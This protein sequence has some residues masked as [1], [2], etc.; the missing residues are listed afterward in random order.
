MSQNLPKRSLRNFLFYFILTISYL[1]ARTI[2]T[3]FYPTIPCGPC[4]SKSRFFL[5][6]CLYISTVSTFLIYARAAT[7]P[8][9]DFAFWARSL[10]GNY[11]NVWTINQSKS[12]P[13][14]WVVTSLDSINGR[15]IQKLRLSFVMLLIHGKGV[16][17]ERNTTTRTH[18]FP[19]LEHTKMLQKTLSSLYFHEMSPWSNVKPYWSFIHENK[20]K[21]LKLFI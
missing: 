8:P 20:K 2:E 6:H 1:T 5:T 9:R 11:A 4:S 21:R 10:G 12:P 19:N 15:S 14:F 18:S 13:G 3:S 16:F 7:V 17:V